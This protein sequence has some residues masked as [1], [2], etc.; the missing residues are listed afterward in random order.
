MSDFHRILLAEDDTNFGLVLK[1]YLEMNDFKVTLSKDGSQARRDFLEK[2]PFDLCILDINMPYK[3]GF[4]LA[5]EIKKIDKQMPLIFLTAKTLHEDQITGYQIG[6]DDYIT[7]PVDS[8]LLLHKARAVIRRTTYDAISRNHV[9]QIGTYKFTPQDRLLSH[10]DFE[11]R[12]SPKESELLNLLCDYQNRITPRDE[13]LLKIWKEDSYFTSRSMDVYI[14]KLRKYL[15]NDTA[16]QI[17]N[18]HGIGYML[19][20]KP[21]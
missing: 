20:V 14:T 18:V 11:K 8:E 1:S 7:K 9:Y 3:D 4:T 6:A 19:N 5:R 2:G 15:S 17:L 16:V 12:L 21:G 13:T 10:S